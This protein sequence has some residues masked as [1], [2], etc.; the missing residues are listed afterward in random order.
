MKGGFFS[1]ES[2]GAPGEGAVSVGSCSASV[3]Y[4]DESA[5]SLQGFV[6]DDV[7]EGN[8][9][10]E[11]LSVDELSS[12]EAKIESNRRV[13]KW[14]KSLARRSGWREVSLFLG[15]KC[16]FVNFMVG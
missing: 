10:D 12:S 14:R 5:G 16:Y 2:S 15:Y 3:D 11:R 9:E 13:R 6:V 8:G 4:D 1:I 7:D